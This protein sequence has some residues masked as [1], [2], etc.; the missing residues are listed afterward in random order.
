VDARFAITFLGRT[1]ATFLVVASVAVL[2]LIGLLPRTGWYRTMTVL[3][4][5]MRPSF[6]PGD[7]VVAR[8]A[9]ADS[10]QV[11]DVLVYRIPVGARQVESH[12]IVQVLGRKPLIVRTKG[13]ANEAADPWTAIIDDGRVW[14]V[15]GSVP[16]VGRVILWL[17]T[18]HLHAITTYL[19]PLLVAMLLL[20]TI[21]RRGNEPEPV[22]DLDVL[23]RR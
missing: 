21:W 4:G 13:D 12:R 20:S 9:S 2:L 6:A 23:H 22:L 11:G 14:T 17:R 19:L 15:R 8:S 18:P 3:T 7:V 5:S 16:W 10:V 1:A